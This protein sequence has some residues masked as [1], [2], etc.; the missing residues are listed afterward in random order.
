MDLT[1]IIGM[2]GFSALMAIMYVQ[3]KYIGY[4]GDKMHWLVS[5]YAFLLVAACTFYPM[6][7]DL[8]ISKRGE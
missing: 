6:Y 1:S 5:F 4:Y 2:Y 7:D 3:V 8:L